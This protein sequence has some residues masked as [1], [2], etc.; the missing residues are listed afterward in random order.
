MPPAV[1]EVSNELDVKAM[2]AREG[3]LESF[4]KVVHDYD[5]QPYQPLW[6]YA[7]STLDRTAVV[8]P[9]DTYKSTTVRMFVE[10]EIGLDPE[11]SI[12]WIMNSGSQSTKNVMTIQA[13]LKGNPVYKRAFPNVEEDTDAQWT[14]EV[15]FVKRKKVDP[16]PTLMATGFNGPYQGLHFNLIILDDLTNQEDVRSDVT[17][18]LQRSK[19]RGVIIDRLMDNGRIVAL[20]TRWG[21]QDLLQTLKEMGF[22]I[23]VMPVIGDYPWGETLS[24]T[25]FHDGKIKQLRRDKGSALFNLTYMCDDSEDESALLPQSQIK[26]WDKDSLPTG[27]LHYFMGVDPAASQ[28]TWADNSAFA[29][30]GLDMKNR[31]KY[32][33]ELWAGKMEVPDLEEFLYKRAR[34][35]AHLRA[36]GLETKGFQ[37]SMLQ[38]MRRKY[39]LPFKEIP[40][41]TQKNAR[42]KIAAMDNDKV[43]RV[44]YLAGQFSSDSL[45]IPRD[46]PLVN[47]VSFESELASIPTRKMDDRMDA[48]TIACVL[49]DGYTP[50]INRGD[51][52]ISAFGGRK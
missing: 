51:Y 21:K 7:L 35:V 46:L 48:V 12:L 3:D 27:R 42:L 28:K 44:L 45:Y 26:Y 2:L 36:F 24:P 11:I 40:Y 39:R 23:I 8:A 25:K 43:G 52:K 50:T 16:N 10:K 18:E 34:G 47:G 29:I 33:V 9:P 41:R 22:N 19:L 38:A 15:M 31:K 5:M 13:T 6:S 4:A 14:K 30:I 1:A 32:L 17:M 49:A 20:F 37:L